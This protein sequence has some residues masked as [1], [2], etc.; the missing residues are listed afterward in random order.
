MSMSNSNITIGDSLSTTKEEYLP[1]PKVITYIPLLGTVF[2]FSEERFLGKSLNRE[3]SVIDAN[4]DRII[5]LFKVL[6]KYRVAHIVRNLLSAALIV[7]GLA[8]GIFTFAFGAAIIGC[9]I[10]QAGLNF[11]TFHKYNQNINHITNHY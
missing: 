2:S 1:L 5:E 8:L 4:N 10:V 7:N 3:M 6:K 11:Y 9:Y